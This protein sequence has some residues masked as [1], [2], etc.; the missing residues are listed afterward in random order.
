MVEDGNTGKSRGTK[1][2]THASTTAVNQGVRHKLQEIPKKAV[3][4]SVGEWK[5]QE[6]KV[7]F[8]GQ[9]PAQNTILLLEYYIEMCM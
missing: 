8:T 3:K 4:T 7:L 5:R 1:L 2:G 6:D 9:C